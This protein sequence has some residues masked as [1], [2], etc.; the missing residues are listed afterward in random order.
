MYLKIGIKNCRFFHQNLEKFRIAIALR[1]S[2][3]FSKKIEFG[4]KGAYGFGDQTW[5]YGATIRSN[6]GRKKRA[7]LSLYYNYDIEQIGLSP[8]AIGMGN[9]F[10][11]LFSTAP[12][13]KLTFLK[14]SKRYM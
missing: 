10:A 5:K 7:V 11:T 3:A 6:I 12:F 13:D 9:T 2:N 14:K 1:T 8:Y 4:I